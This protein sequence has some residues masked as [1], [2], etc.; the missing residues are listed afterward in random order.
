MKDPFKP[1]VYLTRNSG[2]TLPLVGV[3]V[4]AVMLL[5]GVVAIIDSIPLSIKTIYN[6]SRYSLGITM[7]GD[8][9]LTPQ[10]AARIEAE[11]PVP[12][13]RIMVCRLSDMQVKSLVGSWPFAVV[14]MNQEDMAYYVN[15]LGGQKM[16]GRLPNAGAAEAIISEP[17]ARNLGLV[18]G[19]ELLGP[20]KRDAY[21]PMPVRIVGIADTKE[22]MVVIPREYHEQFHF[23]PVD[24]LLVT[25]PTLAE[26]RE[27]DSWALARLQDGRAKVYA[28]QH[29]QEETDQM[30]AILYRILNVVIGMLVAVITLMMG[31]LINI[32]LAQRS[33]E[34]ALLQAIGFRRSQV[35]GRLMKEN[36]IAV[37]LGWILGAIASV[38]LLTVFK[39]T[40]MDP[41]A[42]A[43]DVFY[44]K[45]YAYTIPVPIA[46]YLV[47]WATIHFKLG[48]FDPISVVERRLA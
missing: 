47:G 19:D 33:Q 2:K 10:I 39:V 48:G 24:V 1:A 9:E 11:S 38:V 16:E 20:S 28:F 29:L 37:T 14:G 4:A 36:A 44:W 45:A 41:R 27:F 46:I 17:I 34:F 21:S 5:A 32:Y 6:Y 18:I 7:R 12:I 23:P 15:R 40:L 35:I 8:A 3:I 13:E 26:Q 25:A 30:F 22:W 43:V 42:F 31:M